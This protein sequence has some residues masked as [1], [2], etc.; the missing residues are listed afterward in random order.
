MTLTVTPSGEDAGNGVEFVGLFDKERSGRLL[1]VK[2][3]EL[4]TQTPI[5]TFEV[6]GYVKAMWWNNM[7][8]FCEAVGKEITITTP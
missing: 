7:T 6:E 4:K 8:P 2:K 3:F 1:D 5:G